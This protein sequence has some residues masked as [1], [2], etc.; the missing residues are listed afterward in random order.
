MEQHVDV[1][2]NE[3]KAQAK[4]IELAGEAKGQR[5]ILS[6]KGDAAAI[7]VKAGATANATRIQKHAD[8]ES[9]LAT[10]STEAATIRLQSQTAFNST[11]LSYYLQST[12]YAAI[13]SAVG[14]EENFL[15][16]MKV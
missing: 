6:A 3:A 14:S 9:T 11:N 4:E 10:K 2:I 15:G 8:A 5:I 16:L 13:K 7:L 1:R 12:S